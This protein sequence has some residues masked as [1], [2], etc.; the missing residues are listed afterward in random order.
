MPEAF[1][2]R[3]EAGAVFGL[4]K[5]QADGKSKMSELQSAAER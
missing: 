5:P 2:A 1:A 4:I 3:P